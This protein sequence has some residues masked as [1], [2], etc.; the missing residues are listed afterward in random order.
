MPAR[1]PSP[2]YA[3]CV[4]WPLPAAAE[5]ASERPP[6][7]AAARKPVAAAAAPANKLF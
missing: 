3:P 1:D 4:L 6:H 7:A 2:S 5:V